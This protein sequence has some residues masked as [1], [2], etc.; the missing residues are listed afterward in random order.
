MMESDEK[1]GPALELLLGLSWIGRDEAANGADALAGASIISRTVK[2]VLLTQI[3]FAAPPGAGNHDR[4]VRGCGA[5]PANRLCFETSESKPRH[6]IRL[7]ART[8]LKAQGRKQGFLTPHAPCRCRRPAYPALLSQS[9]RW[10]SRLVGTL[11]Q[12]RR[13]SFCRAQLIGADKWT[14]HA[15]NRRPFGTRLQSGA[16]G[17][18]A[19]RLLGAQGR[20]W[21]YSAFPVRPGKCRYDR[22]LPRKQVPPETNSTLFALVVRSRR[23]SSQLP[24]HPPWGQIERHVDFWSTDYESHFRLPACRR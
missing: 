13:S 11:A 17:S 8:R 15:T 2:V 10:A 24:I 6:R 14:A 21:S 18:Y 12:V 23:L 22:D 1:F 7:S 9:E 16:L 19:V 5:R 4:L 20:R 3:D